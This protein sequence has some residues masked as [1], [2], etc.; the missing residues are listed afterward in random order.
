MPEI[1]MADT[2]FWRDVYGDEQ[3]K[4]DSVTVFNQKIPDYEKI[5]VSFFI[6]FNGF[7]NV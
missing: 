6:L 2:L 1:F 7:T 5:S 3:M 4:R